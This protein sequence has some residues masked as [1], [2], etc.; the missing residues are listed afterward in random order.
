[1][2]KGTKRI[3]ICQRCQK[4]YGYLFC[5]QCKYQRLCTTCSENIH[6]NYINRNHTITIIENSEKRT[7]TELVES[8]I[9]LDFEK[10]IATAKRIQN[11][12]DPTF[13]K[14]RLLRLQELENE[15]R[16]QEEIRKNEEHMNQLALLQS[17]L[18]EKGHSAAKKL[19]SHFR[20]VIKWRKMIDHLHELRNNIEL[21]QV[22][23]S[24]E[25]NKYKFVFSNF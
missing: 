25:T 1:M 10:A 3:R 9:N 20:S 22:W 17:K 2:L 11:I 4:R 19:Q 16:L 23:F 15:K 6:S 7:K 5:Q 8:D 14:A 18:T 13:Q 12:H 24:H 21:G